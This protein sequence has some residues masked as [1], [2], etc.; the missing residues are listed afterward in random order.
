MAKS[1]R[2]VYGSVL[3]ELGETNQ[4]IVVLGAD[5]SGSAIKANVWSGAPP[6]R[7][8][9][10]GIAESNMVATAAGLQSANPRF[11]V[12]RRNVYGVFDGARP[13]CDARRSAAAT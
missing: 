7:F 9:N 11:T 2:E 6:D 5:L 13:D 3:A 12:C 8:F 10:M 1:I 4:D